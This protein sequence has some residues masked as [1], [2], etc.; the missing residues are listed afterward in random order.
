[1]ETTG[2]DGCSVDV[3]GSAEVAGP[4]VVDRGS[5]VLAA[6]STGAG[7]DSGVDSMAVSIFG[8]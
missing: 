4:S 1:M 2:A 5:S 3:E 7:A 6:D 8:A